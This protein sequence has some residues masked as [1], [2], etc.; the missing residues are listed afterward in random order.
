[1]LRRLVLSMAVLACG[2][3]VFA[4]VAAASA[5]LSV[6]TAK[7][8]AAKKADKVRRQL[9][10]EGADRAKVPGCWRNNQRQVSCFFSIYG[11]DAEGGYDWQCML[12]I[13]VKMRDHAQGAR[14]FAYK[15][16]HAVCG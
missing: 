2:A 13:V 5:T 10:T 6:P 12:R 3:G 8:L 7:A 9:K 1:M 16:G 4:G 15:Y 11:H 14:R